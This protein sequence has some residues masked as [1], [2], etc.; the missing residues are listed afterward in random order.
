MRLEMNEDLFGTLYPYIIDDDITDIRW[1]GHSLWVENLKKGRYRTEDILDDDWL[2]IFTQ[3]ISNMQNVSFNASKPSLQASSETL[4]IHCIHPSRTGDH[5]YSLSIRKVPAVVRINEKSIE[6]TKYADKATI[7][8]LAGLVR[9]RYK[10][11][12]IGDVG[13]GKTELLK[14]LARYIPD[15]MSTMTAEDTLEMKLPVLYPGKDISSVLLDEHYPAEQAIRDALRLETRYLWL[16]EARGR[17]I[18]RIMEGASTGCTVWTTIHTNNVWDIP[19]R[20]EQMTGNAGIDKD[21]ENDVFSFFNVGVKVEKV[22]TDN[23]IRRYID[24]ICFFERTE[25]EN[26]TTVIMKNGRYTGEQIPA[27]ILENLRENDEKRLLNLL[28]SVGLI[29]KQK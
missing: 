22:I 23:G 28:D 10:G 11:I 20:I 12:V 1:N 13:A 9:N 29:P 5:T 8:L 4:R 24:Q 2:D 17:E 27:E 26:R 3:R 21:Y 6:E 19:D 7:E 18:A 14:Y 16:A 15:N 25:K